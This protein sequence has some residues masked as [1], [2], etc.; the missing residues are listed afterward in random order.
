MLPSYFFFVN[1]YLERLDKKWM[2]Y[3][4]SLFFVYFLQM[5]LFFCPALRLRSCV[6][7]IDYNNYCCSSSLCSS[8]QL[9]SIFTFLSYCSSINFFLSL[10]FT[11]L[12]FSWISNFNL[13]LHIRLNKLYQGIYFNVDTELT[14]FVGLFIDFSSLLLKYCF[15]KTVH[16]YCS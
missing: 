3:F 16:H 13:S 7:L 2:L 14:V 8:I 9:I 6:L 12:I 11:L 10:S 15:T 1:F 5:T 4:F